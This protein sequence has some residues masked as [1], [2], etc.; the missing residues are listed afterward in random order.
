MVMSRGQDL[1]P[2]ISPALQQEA[3]SIVQ[4]GSQNPHSFLERLSF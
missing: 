4:N 3:R 1:L 2:L